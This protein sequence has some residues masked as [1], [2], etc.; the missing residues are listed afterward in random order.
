MHGNIVDLTCVKIIKPVFL[1][2]Y[3]FLLAGLF[4]HQILPFQYLQ[5]KEIS[6]AVH[7]RQHHVAI[8]VHL[9][10]AVVI[11]PH[12]L[13][14]TDHT[15]HAQLLLG[16]G[17]GHIQNPQFLSQT[18]HLVFM[19]HS[20]EHKSVFYGGNLRIFCLDTDAKLG[21]RTNGLSVRHF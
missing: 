18:F 20:L 4:Q 11:Q 19:S 2:V 7:R 13:Q 6:S 10:A 9:T 14:R 8:M 3:L 16:T 1:S 21:I 12:F 17:H 15:G 5:I